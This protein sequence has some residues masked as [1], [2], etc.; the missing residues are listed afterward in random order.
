[1]RNRGGE[2]EQSGGQDERRQEGKKKH[3]WEEQRVGQQEL[4]VCVTVHNVSNF[5]IAIC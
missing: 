2:K 5:K 1:M 4:Y 3:H